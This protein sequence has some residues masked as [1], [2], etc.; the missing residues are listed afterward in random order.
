MTIIKIN[1]ITMDFDSQ[2]LHDLIESGTYNQDDEI[3]FIVDSFTFKW[4]GT[5]WIE[6]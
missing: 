2:R 3:I 5:T 4:T 1:N 6:V